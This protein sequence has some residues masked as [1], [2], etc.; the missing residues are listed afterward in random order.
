MEYNEKRAAIDL[1][2]AEYSDSNPFEIMNLCNDILNVDITFHELLD[3][4]QASEDFE[5]ISNE[6]QY[7]L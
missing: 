5:K 1:V 2:R 4:L 6:I 3:Y 7:N